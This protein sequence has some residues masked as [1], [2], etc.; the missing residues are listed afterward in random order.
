MDGVF[1]TERLIM[2]PWSPN[3]WPAF[4]ALHFDPD[5]MADYGGPI[6]ELECRRKFDRYLASWNE[7]Q[8]T[9]FSV[10]DREGLFL[11]YCGVVF[12]PDPMHPLGSH[13][14]IGWRFFRD[15]WG[16]GYAMESA[17]ASLVY[18]VQTLNLRSIYAY[19]SPDNLRFQAV[20]ARLAMIRRQDKDF[21]IPTLHIPQWQGLVWMVDPAQFAPESMNTR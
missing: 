7:F 11:G 14:E 17:K 1:E 20:M 21:T 3:H 12:R 9:R 13:H 8:T 16:K 15:S 19:T 2:R 18:A 10:E 6:T 4:C 5:V